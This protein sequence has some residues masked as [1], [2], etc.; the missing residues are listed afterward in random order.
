MKIRLLQRNQRIRVLIIIATTGALAVLS[1][2]Q[3]PHRELTT[4]EAPLLLAAEAVADAHFYNACLSGMH[5]STTHAGP[6]R[7]WL[8][9]QSPAGN[10]RYLIEVRP[11]S[12]PKT[13]VIRTSGS[14]AIYRMLLY[15]SGLQVS[16]ATTLLACLKQ[17]LEDAGTRYGFSIEVIR[18]GQD[19]LILTRTDTVKAAEADR[20]MLMSVSRFRSLADRYPQLLSGQQG[21]FYQ[22]SNVGLASG[23]R[24]LSVGLPVRTREIPGEAMSGLELLELPGAGHLVR[25]IA[26][27]SNR[28]DL[29][30]AMDQYIRD[31]GLKLVAQPF[32]MYRLP[33]GQADRLDSAYAATD[34]TMRLMMPV[35]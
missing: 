28:H 33:E 9:L 30:L 23:L 12:I 32:E 22:V 5:I 34:T 11:G 3:V 15:W 19:S 24:A 14:Y 10:D 29:R 13:V 2:L 35:Y 31:Q 18:V 17:R 1:V 21:V 7:E 16:P 20:Q 8:Y 4:V 25:G 27:R 26:A 6:G